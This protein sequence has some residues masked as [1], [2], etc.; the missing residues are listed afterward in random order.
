MTHDKGDYCTI[1]RCR[2]HMHDTGLRCP[3]PGGGYSDHDTYSTAPCE[4]QTPLEIFAIPDDVWRDA[5][6]P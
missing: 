6:R 3:L 4:A 1:C 2:A 5:G